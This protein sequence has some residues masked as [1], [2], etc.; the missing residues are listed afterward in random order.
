MNFERTLSLECVAT[1]IFN[2]LFDSSYYMVGI[3]MKILCYFS[4][5]WKC[6]DH[7]LV[8]TIKRT[9]RMVYYSF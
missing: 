1:S 7:H 3:V 6:Y 5:L 4:L 8:S 9:V 2:G